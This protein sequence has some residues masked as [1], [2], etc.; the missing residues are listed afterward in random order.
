MFPY[1]YTWFNSFSNFI[2]IN[3][4]F[5]VD[6]W[7]VSGRE[8]AKKINNNEKLLLH[9]DKCIYVAPIHVIQPFISNDYNCVKPFFSIYPKSDEQYILVKY[10]RNIRR[11]NP[12][13]CKLIFTESYNLFVFNNNLKIGEVFLCN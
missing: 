11:G 4:N 13:N 7:G 6:Y 1:Q 5:E 9:K 3:K 10:M 2:N 8:I 12:S